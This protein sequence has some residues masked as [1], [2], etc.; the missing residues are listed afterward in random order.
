MQPMHQGPQGQQG[1]PRSSRRMRAFGLDGVQREARMEAMPKG[2][3]ENIERRVI[4]VRSMDS[5]GD[6]RALLEQLREQLQQ[7]KSQMMK[8]RKDQAGA[9]PENG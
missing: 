2:L 4:E 7:M 3:Q 1:Q 8:M 9:K 5:E 6:P